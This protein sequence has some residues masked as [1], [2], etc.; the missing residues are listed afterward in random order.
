MIFSV[1]AVTVSGFELVRSVLMTARSCCSG[2]PDAGWPSARRS[3]ASKPL[4]FALGLDRG[5]LGNSAVAPRVP[6]LDRRLADGW[7]RQIGQ[8]GL[9]RV[10]ARMTRTGGQSPSSGSL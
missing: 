4:Q 9:I 10:D 6:E 1:A 3:I 2:L 5:G 7:L 8:L